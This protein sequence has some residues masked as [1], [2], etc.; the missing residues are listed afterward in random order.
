MG[1]KRQRQKSLSPEQAQQIL[2]DDYQLHVQPSDA[3]AM[4]AFLENNHTGCRNL[5]GLVLDW[6][7]D[8]DAIKR[9]KLLRTAFQ[10]VQQGDGVSSRTR[11]Q[12]T[13]KLLTEN[14]EEFAQFRSTA[15]RGE[16]EVSHNFDKVDLLKMAERIDDLFR[17]FVA[18]KLARGDDDDYLAVNVQHTQLNQGINVS[19]KV[20]NFDFSEFANRVFKTSQSNHEWLATGK[21]NVEVI[22][23]KGAAG[24]GFSSRAKRAPETVAASVRRRR[25]IIDINNPD[26][27]EHVNACGWW[28]IVLGVVY[29]T[30]GANRHEWRLWRENS[31]NRIACAAKRF[32]E[33]ARIDY[34]SQLGMDNYEQAGLALSPDYQLIVIDGSTTRYLPIYTGPDCARQL[35]VFLHDKIGRAHV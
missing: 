34:N 9:R 4:L 26:S 28:A 24:S 20:K 18:D 15:Y 14:S 3:L 31:G 19:S 1:G 29:W 7:H 16:F 22:L 2:E 35:Y 12:F 32:C 25:C 8:S 5:G 21:F 17:D 30:Q 27:G 6:Q 10:R 11:P 33:F 13:A 23:T